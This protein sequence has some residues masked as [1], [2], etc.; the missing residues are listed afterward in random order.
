LIFRG[1]CLLAVS[2]YG[3]G[4]WQRTIRGQRPR[5]NG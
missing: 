5:A 2:D 1:N 3:N 4:L